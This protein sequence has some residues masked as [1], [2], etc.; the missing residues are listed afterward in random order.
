MPQLGDS[1]PTFFALCFSHVRPCEFF[2]RW[3]VRLLLLRFS[4]KESGR[5]ARVFFPHSPIVL[6]AFFFSKASAFPCHGTFLFPSPN[7]TAFPTGSQ[8]SFLSSLLSRRFWFLI[9]RGEF[10]LIPPRPFSSLLVL[11]ARSVLIGLQLFLLS[12]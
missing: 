1:T 11:G 9:P 10:S 4:V 2:A 5:N 6:S 8:P 12:F 7:F 3:P